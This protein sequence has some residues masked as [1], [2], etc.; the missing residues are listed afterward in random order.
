MAVDSP[1]QLLPNLLSLARIAMTPV[2]CVLLWRGALV[3][4]LG[5]LLLAAATD[6]LDGWLARRNG[7][8]SPL[9]GLLDPLA[10]K[11]LVIGVA[12]M[13]WFL[14]WLPGWLLA[15]LLLRDLV[16]LGGAAAWRLKTGSL[17][18][19]PLLLGKLTTLAVL[20]LLLWTPA[21]RLLDGADWPNLL[22]AGF[23][24]LAGLMLLASGVHYVHVWWWRWLHFRESP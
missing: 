22:L 20:A 19:E 9:G 15:L 7:W 10:D 13:L 8:A 2:I 11:V 14:Q 6:L 16:I 5:W 21:A 3:P 17:K 1:L 12:T 24:W 23:Q 18:G 4:A